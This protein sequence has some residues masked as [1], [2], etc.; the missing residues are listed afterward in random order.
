MNQLPL[1]KRAGW[2]LLVVSAI[3]LALFVLVSIGLFLVGNI[4]V[5]QFEK[6][7][8]FTAT[9]NF[10]TQFFRW[11]FYLALVFFWK[12]IITFVGKFRQW[13]SLVIDRALNDRK[14]ALVSLLAVELLVF[15]PLPMLLISYW[16]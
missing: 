11:A 8:A 1:I 4:S 7:N 3:F 16:R 12:P 14:A 10:Y 5:N 15:Q 2:T 9:L 13:D 6:I